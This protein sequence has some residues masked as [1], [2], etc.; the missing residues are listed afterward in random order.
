[1]RV[2]QKEKDGIVPRIRKGITNRIWMGKR[3]HITSPGGR[4]QT[5]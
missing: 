1:M 2:I 3:F 5:L 4:Y